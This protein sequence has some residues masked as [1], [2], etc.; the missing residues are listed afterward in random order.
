MTGIASFL[1][2]VPKFGHF[3]FAVK[4]PYIN[5]SLIKL[6]LPLDKKIITI[7]VLNAKK[8]VRFD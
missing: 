2:G 5:I 8:E 6:V 3:V 1:H 7:K 4:L